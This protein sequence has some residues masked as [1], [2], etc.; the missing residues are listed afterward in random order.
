M[1]IIVANLP[2]THFTLAVTL[3]AG[4]RELGRGLLDIGL[5][6]VGWTMLSQGQHNTCRVELNKPIN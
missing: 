5:T 3:D 6:V 4:W 2:V 1:G